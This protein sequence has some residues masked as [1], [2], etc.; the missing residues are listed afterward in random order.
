MEKQD[1]PFIL[2]HSN[3]GDGRVLLAKWRPPQLSRRQ[4][5][6]LALV[7]SDFSDKQIAQRLGIS[8]H[9]VSKHMER[10]FSRNGFHS[11]PAAVA[12]WL[13]RPYDS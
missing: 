10:L 2:V 8:C 9:T 13:A 4:A 6:V 11:R 3:A 5:D 12:A 7:A 1:R